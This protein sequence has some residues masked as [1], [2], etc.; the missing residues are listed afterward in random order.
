MENSEELNLDEFVK[1]VAERERKFEADLRAHV[2]RA[3][4]FEQR[5][6]IVVT[7]KIGREVQDLIDDQ[8]LARELLKDIRPEM[9]TMGMF[10][11]SHYCGTDDFLAEACEK[12][13][14]IE[15]DVRAK[16]IAISILGQHY[17]K[18]RD[19]R[20]ASVL[21]RIRSSSD[22]PEEIRRAA[23]RSFKEV[24]NPPM[25]SGQ[26]ELDWIKLELESLNAELEASRSMK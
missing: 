19:V 22:E 10:V 6:R 24:A 20:I 26:T 21:N 4:E 14:A 12:S 23:D 3:N 9:R 1:T 15:T 7:K 11:L 8:P 13:L 17:S 2:A 25:P 16:K 5:L 18:S